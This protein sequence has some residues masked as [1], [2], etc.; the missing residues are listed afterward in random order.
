MFCF[1]LKENQNMFL[2]RGNI[3]RS[4]FKSTLE[5]HSDSGCK[6]SPKK[7]PGTR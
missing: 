6:F 4:I 3:Q 7:S 2:F 1:V 5:I